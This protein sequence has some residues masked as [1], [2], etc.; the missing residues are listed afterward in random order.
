MKIL[1]YNLYGKKDVE[2]QIPAFNV[3]LKNL[4]RIINNL[5]N[6]QSGLFLDNN[7]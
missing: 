1:S 5:V 6:N 3:R 7:L 4:D 2:N